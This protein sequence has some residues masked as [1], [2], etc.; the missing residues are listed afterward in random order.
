M[1]EALCALAQC[2]C[3]GRLVLTLVLLAL[4]V[5]A[6]AAVQ[7]V[8]LRLEELRDLGAPLPP[9]LAG[10][11]R[12]ALTFR[13]FRGCAKDYYRAAV[14]ATQHLWAKHP[15]AVPSRT[16]HVP[17]TPPAWGRI[18]LPTQLAMPDGSSWR[19]ELR[20]VENCGTEPWDSIL[21]PPWGVE[22]VL[23]GAEELRQLAQG[24]PAS[25]HHFASPEGCLNPSVCPEGLLE[26]QTHL[27][28]V[29]V[30][31]A[32]L[33]L[34]QHLAV[35]GGRCALAVARAL[36]HF[37]EASAFFAAGLQVPWAEVFDKAE[38]CAEQLEG[39]FWELLLGER[40]WPGVLDTPVVARGLL[41]GFRRP[42]G[43]RAFACAPSSSGPG[44]GAVLGV[45]PRADCTAGAV[46]SGAALPVLPPPVG[47]FRRAHEAGR[48]AREH[49]AAYR[50]RALR[51]PRPRASVVSSV[52]ERRF[53]VAVCITGLA[54]NFDEPR[55]LPSARGPTC[56]S[57]MP[58]TCRAGP[59]TTSTRPSARCH[60]P[61]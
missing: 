28:W 61:G 10:A 59:C 40:D 58:W 53:A 16:Y 3:C 23:A 17:V 57:S 43:L 51:Q 36:D 31:V 4:R 29:G 11:E 46:V 33:T 39:S 32:D 54:R 9:E 6:A 15:G 37:S 12:L 13:D 42:G 49:L 56:P 45:F 50:A 19:L 47:T 24:L 21:A 52:P 7:W 44:V 38:R 41:P 30:P 35:R 20:D 22:V 14:A 8:T 60:R 1:A 5:P 18:R 26:L 34:A 55:V 48:Y 27:R 25:G 2:R